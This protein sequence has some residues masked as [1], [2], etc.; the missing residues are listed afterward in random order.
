LLLG[1]DGIDGDRAHRNSAA[2]G[3]HVGVANGMDSK[4]A[5]SVREHYLHEIA[6]L[7]LGDPGRKAGQDGIG[8]ENAAVTE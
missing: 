4:I 6:A 8:D 5:G 2:F 7:A 3:I 1:F